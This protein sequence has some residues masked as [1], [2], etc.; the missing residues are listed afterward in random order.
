MRK[1]QRPHDLPLMVFMLVL[2]YAIATL[3]YILEIWTV[4]DRMPSLEDTRAIPVACPGAIPRVRDAS[5]GAL[6]SQCFCTNTFLVCVFSYPPFHRRALIKQIYRTWLI[7]D[8]NYWSIIVQV[9][10]NV[11]IPGMFGSAISTSGLIV[12]QCL[13][14]NGHALA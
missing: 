13:S 9:V 3:Q 14:G 8:K 2:T 1:S 7:W 11:S 12:R 10:F 6:V 5:L 4:A